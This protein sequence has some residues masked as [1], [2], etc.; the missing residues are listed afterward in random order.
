MSLP[1]QLWTHLER[2]A[3]ERGVS[4][5]DLTAEALARLIEGDARYLAAR[6]RALA[7]LRNAPSLTLNGQITWT[8]DELH[9][10]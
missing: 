8:R 7:R 1:G 5:S 10:R 9:E 4:I 3:A 2:L 6:E